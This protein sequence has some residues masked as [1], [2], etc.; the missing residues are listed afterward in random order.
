[1]S[2]LSGERS[3]F[4]KSMRMPVWEAVMGMSLVEG[5]PSFGDTFAEVWIDPQDGLGVVVAAVKEATF[6]KEDRQRVEALFANPQTDLRIDLV[7]Y[8]RDDL[9]GYV[10]RLWEQAPPADTLWTSINGRT[11][12]VIV[13]TD[14]HFTVAG[15]PAEALCWQF[16]DRTLDTG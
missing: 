11:G 2:V 16:D 9:D 8:S 7:S 12:H 14:E 1:M 5:M 4:L 10:E 6:D 13:G 3:D 15:V